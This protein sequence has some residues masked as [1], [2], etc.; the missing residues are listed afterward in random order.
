MGE[1]NTLCPVGFT[2]LQSSVVFEVLFLSSIRFF[3]FLVVAFYIGAKANTL[4]CIMVTRSAF[5]GNH[6]SCFPLLVHDLCKDGVG[7]VQSSTHLYYLWLTHPFDLLP[8]L[9]YIGFLH[10]AERKAAQRVIISSDFRCESLLGGTSF[11]HNILT[12]FCLCG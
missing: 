6:H 11:S 12:L 3:F 2:I 8:H 5:F 10:T 7:N 1:D 4:S 9:L